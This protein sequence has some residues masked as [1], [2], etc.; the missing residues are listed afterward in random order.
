MDH[1]QL[2]PTAS[3]QTTQKCW[4][5]GE[6]VNAPLQRP[7]VHRRGLFFLPNAPQKELLAVQQ[8]DQPHKK[9]LHL[10]QKD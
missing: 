7:P 5:I 3:T 2:Q 1:H 4:V 6:N 8:S 10:P 9:E